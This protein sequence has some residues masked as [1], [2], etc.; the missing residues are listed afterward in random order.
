ICIRVSPLSFSDCGDLGAFGPATASV[1]TPSVATCGSASKRRVSSDN[2]AN[3]SENNSGGASCGGTTPVSR[4][5]VGNVEGEPLSM[6]KLQEP[7]SKFQL[8]RCPLGFG[9]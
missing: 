4:S 9:A 7:N 1:F 6:V 2:S 3:K 5:S 8:R